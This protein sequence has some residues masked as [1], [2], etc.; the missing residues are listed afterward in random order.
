MNAQGR[1]P[2]QGS[3]DVIQHAIRLVNFVVTK[4]DFF[5]P[6]GVDDLP[7]SEVGLSH[8]VV[9]DDKLNRAF[10]VVLQ[11]RLASAKDH[12]LR[13]HVDAVALFNT[14]KPIDEPFKSSALAHVNAP[15]IAFPFLR[16]FMASFTVNAGIPRM[17]LPSVN[18]HQ[19]YKVSGDRPGTGDD[20]SEVAEPAP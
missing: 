4:V 5:V 15:A 8:K 19:V 11:L 2:H 14:D 18:F 12:D 3:T 13:L 17:L 10:M 6:P 1:E 7:D 20:T 16:S 9:F